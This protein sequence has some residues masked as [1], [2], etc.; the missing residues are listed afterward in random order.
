MSKKSIAISAAMA[1]ILTSGTAMADVT[2]N[3]GVVSDYVFRGVVQNTSAAGNGGLDWSDDSGIYAGVWATNI[4]G[5]AGLANNGGTGNG[6][7]EIDLYAG[8][9]GEMEDISYSIGF[10]HYGYTGDFD[11]SY[12]EINLGAGYGDFSLDIAIGSHEAIAPATTDDDYT[13]VSL[14][15]A[16]GPF[17]ASYNTFSGDWGGAFYEF[18]MST[19]IGGAEAGISIVNG[20]PEDNFAGIGTNT[21]DGT[22]MIF[23]L[24]KSFDL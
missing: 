21:T 12:D 5:Q 9:G 18:G 20:D 24:S 19:D 1:A 15:Y 13:F 8:Y 14:G 4:E 22:T 2:A 3:V 11:S 10:T 7:L 23:S 6:G 16:T 17:Y